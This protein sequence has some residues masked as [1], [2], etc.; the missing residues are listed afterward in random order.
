MPHIE[1][2]IE[3]R[4]VVLL[5]TTKQRERRQRDDHA[6]EKTHEKTPVPEMHK[7]PFFGPFSYYLPYPANDRRAMAPAS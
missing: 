7:G 2:L 6:S 4:C 3:W 5:A 1:L